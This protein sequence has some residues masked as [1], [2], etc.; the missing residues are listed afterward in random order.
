MGGILKTL[1]YLKIAAMGVSFASILPFI[2]CGLGESVVTK[3]MDK[4]LDE[5]GY[6]YYQS[7]LTNEINTQLENNDISQDEYDAEMEK[8]NDKAAFLKENG[9]PEQFDQFNEIQNKSQKLHTAMMISGISSIASLVV[10]CAV[11][12]SELVHT[13]KTGKIE[14]VNDD[15]EI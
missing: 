15:T 5:S 2:G 8:I 4:L 13:E 11:I 10:T 6:T 1:K 3:D 9:S 12:M 7:Q 14:L